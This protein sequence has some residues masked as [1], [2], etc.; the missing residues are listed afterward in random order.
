MSSRPFG[1]KINGH[2]WISKQ[3]SAV[4]EKLRALFVDLVLDVVT[5]GACHVSYIW[6]ITLLMDITEAPLETRSRI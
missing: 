2:A 5:C 6:V 3:S 1:A 4:G